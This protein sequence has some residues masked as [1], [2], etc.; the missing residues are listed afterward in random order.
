MEA[1]KDVLMSSVGCAVQ[2]GLCLGSPS[3][4]Y[5]LEIIGELG[6]RSVSRAQH[7]ACGLSLTAQMGNL[8]SFQVFSGNIY[9]KPS[10]FFLR[11]LPGPSAKRGNTI[12]HVTVGQ[13]LSLWWGHEDG[14]RMVLSSRSS[15]ASGGLSFR[16]IL[17]EGKEIFGV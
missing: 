3:R 16:Y 4:I 7:R 12:A 10:P 15:Q 2:S 14:W 11:F 6:G 9:L 5:T 8:H 13:A 17:I 1:R